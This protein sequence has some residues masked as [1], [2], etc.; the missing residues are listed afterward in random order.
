MVMREE[1]DRQAEWTGRLDL[2]LIDHQDRTIGMVEFVVHVDTVCVYFKNRNMAS[3][4]RSRFRQ[5]L[6]HPWV[7]MEADE[8]VWAARGTRRTLGL[9]ERGVFDVPQTFVDH[10]IDVI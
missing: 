6:L 2:H 8:I 10:L 7:V 9:G 3:M 5:W 4:V 1:I